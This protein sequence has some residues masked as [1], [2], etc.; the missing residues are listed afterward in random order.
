VIGDESIQQ[1]LWQRKSLRTIAKELG[2]HYSTLSREI[3]RNLPPERFLYTPR[4]AQERALKKRKSRGRTDRLKNDTIRSYA[5][6]HLKLRWSPEQIANRISKD[7]PEA[8]ISYEAIY[9]YIYHQIHRKGYGYL[10]PGCEDLRLYLRRKKKRRTPKGKRRCQRIFRP[11]GTSIDERPLV[12]SKRARL[13]DW[14]GDTVASKDN[15][16]GINTLVERKTGLILITKLAD[17]TGQA[18]L[19]AVASRLSV[20]P[21]EARQTLT[22]DNGSENSEW[23]TMEEEAGL[24][25]FFCNPYHAWERGTNEN[26]NGLVRDYFPKKTDFSTIPQEELQKVEYLLNTRPRKRLSW[27][28]PL[29]ALMLHL[30]VEST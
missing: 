29:E 6:N 24:R 14:E 30:G 2:R 28:T 3:D 13:G 22:M 20:F 19:K 21:K 4:L 17:R 15:K 9:Q 25:C 1:G 23:Q 10:K 18:T 16:P 8:S 11:K 26:T 12:V 27:L 5:I 7:I